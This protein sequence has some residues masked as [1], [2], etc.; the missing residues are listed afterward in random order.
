MLEVE[1]EDERSGAMSASRIL[2]SLVLFAAAEAAVQQDQQDPREAE[3]T[4]LTTEAANKQAGQFKLYLQEA[5]EPA[6]IIKLLQELANEGRHQVISQELMKFVRH[7]E[8]EVQLE[9]L[10]LLGT[11]RD[12][13]AQKVLLSFCKRGAR[14][15]PLLAEEAAR[16]LGYTGYGKRGYQQ[17]EELFYKEPH[18]KL[19][20]AILKSFGQQEEKAAVPLLITLLDQPQPG[21]VDSA[22]NPPAAYWQQQ[23]QQWRLLNPTAIRS[24]SEITGRRFVKSEDAEEWVR[25]E[26]KKIGLKFRRARSPWSS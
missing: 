15:D 10:R 8:P 25:T 16:S 20:R 1:R 9:S 17:L 7:R 21:S 5:R 24:L 11:Q 26:G 22:S 4:T 2:F 23:Y 12:E 6:E 13:T 14:F 3:L 19:R 18:A